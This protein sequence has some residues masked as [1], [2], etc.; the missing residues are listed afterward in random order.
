M[1]KL[2]RMLGQGVVTEEGGDID[3]FGT[4]RSL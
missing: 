2:G 3:E 4:D 1:G